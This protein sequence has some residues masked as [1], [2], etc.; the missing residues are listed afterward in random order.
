MPNADVIEAGSGP[1]VVL[2]HSS[3]AG[4]RQW[5]RLMTESQDRFH[6]LAVN[7]IGYGGTPPWTGDRE[8]TLDDQADLVTSALPDGSCRVHVVGHSTGGAVAMK[9]AAHLGTRVDKLVLIE[10]NPFPLLKQN[11]RQAAF[12]ECLTV[13]RWIKD[14]GA[15][16]DWT[17][18]AEKFADYWGGDGAWASMPEDRRAAFTQALKPNYHEWDAVLGDTTTLEAWGKLLPDDTLLACARR[19]VLPIRGIADL[20]RDAFPRWRFEEIPDGGHMAP[21]TRPDLVNPMITKFLDGR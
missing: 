2:L 16:G 18:A 13:R 14:A 7:L 20:M 3:V 15:S 8:Q 10:P 4:A 9:T 11:A 19:T 21:L 1:L 5:H 17:T 6:F 12:D